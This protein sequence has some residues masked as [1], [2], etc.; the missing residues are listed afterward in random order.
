ML[1]RFNQLL[2]YWALG[3]EDAYGQSTFAAPTTIYGRWED[4]NE[5][6]R[7][8]NGDVFVSRSIVWSD[9]KLTLGGYVARGDYTDVAS[10]HL[11]AEAEQILLTM[12]VPALRA[13][14]SEYRAIV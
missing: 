11:V 8:P 6:V 9:F 3:N 4:R 1:M 2:T 14:A 12:E 7:T 10:P 5:E 13:A